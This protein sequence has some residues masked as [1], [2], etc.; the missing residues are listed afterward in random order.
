M[1]NEEILKAIKA[2]AQKLGRNP[3][4]RELEIM[5]G[6]TDKILWRRFGNLGNALKAA[7]LEPSGRGVVLAE[8]TLLQDWAAV[9]RKL[10][11]IPS[12]NEY[13]R[14]GMGCGGSGKT[15]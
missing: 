11:K 8:V 1:T 15:C 13:R 5:T 14:G 6:I 2:C 9:V 12:V 7:G 3:K 10:G 4:Q